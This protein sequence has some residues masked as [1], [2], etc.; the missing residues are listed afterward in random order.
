MMRRLAANERRVLG[1]THDPWTSHV[2]VGMMFGSPEL[3]RVASIIMGTLLPYPAEAQ[4]AVADALAGL[5]RKSRDGP[6][7]GTGRHP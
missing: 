6:S 5:A 4:A 7:G 1:A 3:G 2:G